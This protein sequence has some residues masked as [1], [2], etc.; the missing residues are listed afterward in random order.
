MPNSMVLGEPTKSMAP[1]TPPPDCSSTCC[2]A[3]A[4]RLSTVPAHLAGPRAL[5]RVDVGHQHPSAEVA[6]RDVER[7]AADAAGADDQ[8]RVGDVDPIADLLEGAER[9]DA[10]AGVGRSQRLRYGAVVDQIAGVRDQH[11]RGIA[12]G[13]PRAERAR[14]QA[15]QLVAL[16]AHGTGPA[17]DPRV[18]GVAL[19]DLDALRL[20]P[21]RDDKA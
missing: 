10:R 6:G 9:R 5:V 14:R 7:L 3:S 4:A 12:P 20:R 1:A 21:S 17:A 18:D 19:A 8:E 15:Q 16:P 2:R 11:V 13:G